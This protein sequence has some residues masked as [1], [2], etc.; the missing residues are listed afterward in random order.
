MKNKITALIFLSVLLLTGCS[1]QSD[2]ISEVTDKNNPGLSVYTQPPEDK[3][4]KTDTINSGEDVFY[5]IYEAL[6]E[7]SLSKYIV[8]EENSFCID[9][10]LYITDYIAD[11]NREYVNLSR[12]ERLQMAWGDGEFWKEYHMVR[13][14]GLIYIEDSENRIVNNCAFMIFSENNEASKALILNGYESIYNML[15]N[16]DKK[17]LQEFNINGCELPSY[18]GVAFGCDISYDEYAISFIMQENL[19][20]KETEYLVNLYQN[21]CW[22][23]RHGG[24]NESCETLNM[25]YTYDYLT[26]TEHNTYEECSICLNLYGSKGKLKEIKLIYE[27][28]L[29][30]IPEYCQPTIIECL[31]TLGCSDDAITEFMTK[32]PDKSGNIDNLYFIVEKIDKNNSSIK[33][34]SE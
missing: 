15:E 10:E 31:K 7:T 9:M 5:G 17:I 24:T 21:D 19:I 33:V 2:F 26:E 3:Y 28:I 4:N 16:L 30:E 20:P 29:D 12:D 23:I 25:I 1:G 22:T 27:N 11:N 8:M 32:I 13:Q 18:Y 6:C 14:D 34:Y